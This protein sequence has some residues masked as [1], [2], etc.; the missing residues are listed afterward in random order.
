[1]FFRIILMRT[2]QVVGLVFLAAATLAQ[3]QQ[4]VE[5]TSEPSHHLVLE[6]EVVRVFNVTVAAKASTLVHR[7]N[8]DYI[9]VTL[10]DSDVVSTRVGEKPVPLH[11]RDGEVRFTPGN[12]AHAAINE[13]EQ[14][15]HNIT[16]ELLKASTN[17][18]T[19]T[20]SCVTHPAC[21]DAANSSCPSSEK[22][23][24]SDQWT[25]SLV[26]MPPSSRLE[27]HT[28]AT[29]H[30]VVPVSDLDLTQQTDSASSAIRRAPGE[31]GWVPGGV[32]HTLINS[33]SSPARF[34]ALEFNA[35]KQ[36]Q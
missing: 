9:F 34:V 15:F 22:R 27:K 29:P 1:M 36:S 35:G 6:N 20:E 4:P 2:S 33:S 31:I 23:I 17:V 8:S 13:R 30:L 21:A 24:S 12:F 26:T 25:I 11:L 28:H 16:I 18:K 14:P 7:H 5:I 10:G 32:T 19:C 3:E